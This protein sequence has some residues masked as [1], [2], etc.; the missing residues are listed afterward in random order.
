[1]RC[2]ME[3]RE[4]DTRKVI[5]GLKI[6]SNDLADCAYCYLFGK[7]R[8]RKDLLSDALEHIEELEREVEYFSEKH[9][10]TCIE[11]AKERETK[12]IS[13]EERL[14]KL[15][16]NVI[17]VNKETGRSEPYYFIEYGAVKENVTHWMYFPT[18]PKPKE[19]TFR[20]VFLKEFPKAV[21]LEHSG[22]PRVCAKEVF[23]QLGDDE[24]PCDMRCAVCW[25]Q[26]YFEEEEEG[27]ADGK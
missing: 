12:W 2:G 6:C 1:M 3:L 27:E 14:P 20:D 13:V 21:V 5:A 18:P 15:R 24:S 17:G 25:S 26:P 10:E 7:D 9:N 23:P 16:K 22:V 11:L 4:K 8:C 19:P